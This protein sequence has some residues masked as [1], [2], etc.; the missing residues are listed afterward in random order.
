MSILSFGAPA[1]FFLRV[2][3]FSGVGLEL[4][5]RV[6]KARNWGGFVVSLEPIDHET[7]LTMIKTKA[8]FIGLPNFEGTL[9]A[10]FYKGNQQEPQFRRGFVRKTRPTGQRLNK[11]GPQIAMAHGVLHLAFNQCSPMPVDHAVKLVFPRSA[12]T[13]AQRPRKRRTKKN[14]VNSF[15]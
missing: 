10:R 15:L 8:G 11:T 12:E 5:L 7:G 13:S 3:S 6:T 9:F 14:E 4:F 2:R 1:F